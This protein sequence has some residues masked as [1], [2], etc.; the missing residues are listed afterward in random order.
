LDIFISGVE[1][2][3]IHSFNSNSAVKHYKVENR[4]CSDIYLWHNSAIVMLHFQTVCF[5]ITLELLPEKMLLL[6]AGACRGLVMV[7]PPTKF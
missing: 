5:V 1:V 7:M 3:K 4:L 2:L 6:C